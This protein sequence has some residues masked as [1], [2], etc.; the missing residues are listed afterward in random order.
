[1]NLEQVVNVQEM[2]HY[3]NVDDGSADWM[4]FGGTHGDVIWNN[5]HAYSAYRN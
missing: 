3:F 5:L 1:M 4:I 2:F